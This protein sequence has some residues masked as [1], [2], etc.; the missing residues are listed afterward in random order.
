MRGFLALEQLHLLW[1]PL[2]YYTQSSCMYQVSWEGYENLE[3]FAQ[4]SWSLL[5]IQFTVVISWDHVIWGYR[6]SGWLRDVSFTCLSLLKQ[7]QSHLWFPGWISSLRKQWLT[8]S[9]VQSADSTSPGSHIYCFTCLPKRR[10]FHQSPNL[11]LIKTAQQ[12]KMQNWKKWCFNKW[13]LTKA[14]WAE[15]ICPQWN[16]QVHVHTGSLDQ[17]VQNKFRQTAGDV[18]L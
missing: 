17:S 10:I 1:S 6:V 18:W 3:S 15:S 5:K 12:N 11:Y 14:L 8:F 7:I 9:A 13:Y 2:I 16:Q 4:L